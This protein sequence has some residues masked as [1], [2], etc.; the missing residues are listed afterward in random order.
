M[1]L[2]VELSSSRTERDPRQALSVVQKQLSDSDERIRSL[3]AEHRLLRHKKFRE[4]N[5]LCLHKNPTE[6]SDAQQTRIDNLI[7]AGQNRS[8]IV[9]ETCR[10][11]NAVVPPNLRKAMFSK[12]GDSDANQKSR[13][14]KSSL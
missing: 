11:V 10:N 9:S 7:A 5:I 14:V 6:R 1:S 13:P 12:E 2:P 3:I 8:T 4:E